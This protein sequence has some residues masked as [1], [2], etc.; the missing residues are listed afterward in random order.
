[1]GTTLDFIYR[2]TK[3]ERPTKGCFYWVNSGKV[4]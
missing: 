4:N 3:P 2:L 1:M